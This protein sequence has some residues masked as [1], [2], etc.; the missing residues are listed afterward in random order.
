MNK[1][2][3]T[4][5]WIGLCMLGLFSVVSAQEVR[6]EFK[7]DSI[8]AVKGLIEENGILPLFEEDIDRPNAPAAFEVIPGP[9]MGFTIRK[10][11]TFYHFSH[12]GK[13]EW[14]TTW[15]FRYHVKQRPQIKIW[16]DESSIWVLEIKNT[17]NLFN[18]IILTRLGKSGVMQSAT[19]SMEGKTGLYSQFMSEKAVH[20]VVGKRGEPGKKEY[21][22]LT[23]DKQ[24]LK[25]VE[26]P[27]V[28]AEEGEHSR[29]GFVGMA[30]FDWKEVAV[31]ENSVLLA[32]RKRNPESGSWKVSAVEIGEEGIIGKIQKLD[33]SIDP[34]SGDSRNMPGIFWD[35]KRNE[36]HA[37][38]TT[39]ETVDKRNLNGFYWHKFDADTR[40]SL[41][42]RE[43]R[44]DELADEL[45]NGNGDANQV[46]ELMEQIL[47]F[48][49]FDEELRLFETET[50]ALHLILVKDASTFRKVNYTSAYEV[51]MNAKGDITGVF[52]LDFPHWPSHF[53]GYWSHPDEEKSLWT[54]K[55][56]SLITEGA[57]P[58]TW[59]RFRKAKEK[60][61]IWKVIERE[62]DAILLGFDR[63]S[64]SV[65]G[66]HL[67]K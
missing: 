22:L 6:S 46:E 40:K 18:E 59:L 24:T 30:L 38:G 16:T 65:N 26:K 15:K 50:G 23:I 57:D 9:A 36:L 55:Q 66:I 20:L 19:F 54:P 2:L 41:M 63:K 11:D 67:V 33:L 10:Q 60:G 49:K 1:Q 56:T 21:E 25:W 12:D 13:L 8:L 62:E 29:G 48:R 27:I 53:P 44:F 51:R 14:K 35:A 64:G 43:V 7:I 61:K 4:K 39:Y 42:A 52:D 28:L 58:L 17:P 47:P 34:N 32:K 37:V 31:K 45:S 3:L 5:F